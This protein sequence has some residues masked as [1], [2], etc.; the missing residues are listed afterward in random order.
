[1]YTIYSAVNEVPPD[2]T[3]VVCK[4][5]HDMVFYGVTTVIICM[6]NNV[7]CKTVCVTAYTAQWDTV[8][9]IV[10]HVRL[11]CVADKAAKALLEGPI[12]IYNEAR[13]T[14]IVVVGC[15]AICAAR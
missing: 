4:D 10:I 15:A 5:A 3:G 13:D 2:G 12:L 11:C 9:T 14:V 1:M 7:G 6:S 8:Y